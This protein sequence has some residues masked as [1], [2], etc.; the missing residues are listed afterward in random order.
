MSKPAGDL[1]IGVR[2]FSFGKRNPYAEVSELVPNE[3]FDVQSV[4]AVAMACFRRIFVLHVENGA[5]IA[6]WLSF[7]AFRCARLRTSDE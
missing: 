4:I 7:A 6:G 2:F 3:S 1:E 5:T